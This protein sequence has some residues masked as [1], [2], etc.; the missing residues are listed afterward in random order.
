MNSFREQITDEG[1]ELI[2]EAQHEIWSSWMR[3]LLS[4]SEQNPDGTVTIPADKV[5]RWQRQIGTNYADLTE[6]EKDGDREQA[7]KVVSICLD[8]GKK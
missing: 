4:V 2:A 7:E 8:L 5:Q 6:Q 1:F 3:H